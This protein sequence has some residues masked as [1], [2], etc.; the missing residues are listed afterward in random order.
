MPARYI[1]R[2]D[3]STYV[4][5]TF[6]GVNEIACDRNNND[7]LTINANGSTKVLVD[8]SSTQSL[9]GK[10]VKGVA[11]V[12]VTGNTTL[13]AAAHDGVF[14]VINAAAGATLTLP[15]AT[16]SGATY[17]IIVGTTLTSGSLVVQVASNADYLRGFAYTVSGGTSSTFAT[18]N[19]GTVATES[20]TITFNRSTT[21]LGTI[22][23]FIEVVDIKPH[24]WAVE[25]TYASSGTAATP[26]SAAV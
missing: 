18:A 9:S 7:L 19:T 10:T 12:S 5:K 15:A 4:L 6:D 14:V 23:D 11:P 24:V 16:G 2:K 22:G 20:D 26:F 1:Q 13:T 25:A 8:T 21:G 3:L 17:R